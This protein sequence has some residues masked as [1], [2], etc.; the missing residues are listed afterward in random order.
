MVRFEQLKWSANDPKQGIDLVASRLVFVAIFACFVANVALAHDVPK[1][2]CSVP[3][4][5]ID[6][7]DAGQRAFLDQQI[8]DFSFCVSEFV[9]SQARQIQIHQDSVKAAG[10]DVQRLVNLQQRLKNTPGN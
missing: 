5:E 8:S 10:S 7:E 2:D 9:R 1:H 6:Y 4:L 3:N